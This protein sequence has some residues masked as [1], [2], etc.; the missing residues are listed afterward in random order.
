MDPERV[1]RLRVIVVEMD[2][3]TQDIGPKLIRLAH[4]R[5]EAKEIVAEEQTTDD[6]R[7]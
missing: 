3:I 4:L 5:K 6:E 7:R 2:R 1:E